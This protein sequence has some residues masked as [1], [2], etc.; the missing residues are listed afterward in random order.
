MT[1]ASFQPS[2][3]VL[4]SKVSYH[5]NHRTGAHVLDKGR[6]EWF[7]LQVN[8]VLHQQVFTGLQ[9]ERAI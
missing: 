9:Q 4:C 8:V 2:T 3:S 5:S 6:K 7:F 1:A